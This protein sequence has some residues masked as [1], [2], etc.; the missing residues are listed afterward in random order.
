VF[1]ENMYRTSAIFG[2]LQAIEIKDKNG[3]EMSP[4][5]IAET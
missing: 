5:A 3:E 4:L 1:V 2:Y